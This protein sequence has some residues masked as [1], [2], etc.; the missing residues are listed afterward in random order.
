M[1]YP[2]SLYRIVLGGTIY[3]ET[4]NTS[5]SYAPG[6]LDKP[7]DTSILA[8]LA[9][10]TQSW[11]QQNQTVGVG[12]TPQ[13][14]LV[15]LKVNRIDTQGH[16]QDPT[17]IMHTYPVP[18]AGGGTASFPPA[19]LATVVT[20]KTAFERGLANKGR[21]YLPCATGYDSVG[22]DGRATAA[23]A[24]LVANSVAGYVN[25]VN[26]AFQA[27]S[28]GGDAGHVAVFSN[29]GSGAF[30]FVTKTAVG[31][32]PDTMRSRRSSLPE[33]YQASTTAVP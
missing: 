14:K 33:D 21:M 30:H 27:W 1:A 29:I 24:L 22:T 15:Y 18:L 23:R 10:A 20:L 31:R 17:A 32:V 4:W 7:A 11:F 3:T 28:G 8:T 26:A 2:T 5:L 25:Q 9:A 19:Q 13:A 6:F 12:F 16:Y